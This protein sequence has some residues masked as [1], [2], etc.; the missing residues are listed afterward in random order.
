MDFKLTF[1][2]GRLKVFSECLVF[3]S[4]LLSPTRTLDFPL[5][6]WETHLGCVRSDLSKMLDVLVISASEWGLE[7]LLKAVSL[8]GADTAVLLKCPF[9]EYIDKEQDEGFF[10]EGEIW[11]SSP[12]GRVSIGVL[13]LCEVL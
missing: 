11:M 1:P 9:L 12:E 5:L 2:L 7:P 8:E 13:M 3:V 10:L 6:L 4:F